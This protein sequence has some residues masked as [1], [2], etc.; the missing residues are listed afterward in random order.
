MLLNKDPKFWSTL[1]C[2]VAIGWWA[3]TVYVIVSEQQK[4]VQEVRQSSVHPTLQKFI[5]SVPPNTMLEMRWDRNPDLPD[6]PNMALE[7]SIP[8][9]GR[10]AYMRLL[11]GNALLCGNCLRASD[12]EDKFCRR[13]GTEFSDQVMEAVPDPEVNLP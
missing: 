5:D 6:L 12:Q 11:R 4:K 2:G 9:P 7:N 3:C 10:R 8:T 1:A 13:C